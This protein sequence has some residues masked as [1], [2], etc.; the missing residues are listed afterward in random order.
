[1]KVFI[2]KDFTG[3]WPVGTA[4]VILAEDDVQAKFYLRQDLKARGLGEQTVFTVQEIS[5]PGAHILCD[6]NY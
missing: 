3:H 2:S 4:A 1:M 5:G 6:G